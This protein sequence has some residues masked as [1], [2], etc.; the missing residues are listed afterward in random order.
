MNVKMNGDTL[1][2]CKMEG[3]NAISFYLKKEKMKR[4]IPIPW[5]NCG[6]F[7]KKSGPCR[8]LIST[9]LTKRRPWLHITLCTEERVNPSKWCGWTMEATPVENSG[10]L[11]INIEMSNEGPVSENNVKLPSIGLA[12]L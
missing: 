2:M 8:Q 11:A 5:T 1:K 10:V 6:P 9:K 4:L 12:I 7:V 3:P